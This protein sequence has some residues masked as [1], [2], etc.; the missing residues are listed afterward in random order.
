LQRKIGMVLTFKTCSLLIAF[1]PH[2][3]RILHQY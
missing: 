1:L 2:W 3:V